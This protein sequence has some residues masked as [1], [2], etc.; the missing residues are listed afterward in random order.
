MDLRDYVDAI[1]GVAFVHVCDT[2]VRVPLGGA[3]YVR[4]SFVFTAAVL[5]RVSVFRVW[6]DGMVTDI[7][8]VGRLGKL[9]QS[10]VVNV[11]ILTFV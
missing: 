4:P 5:V 1:V 6:I 8:C 10:L 7:C 3:V 11:G 2:H 9:A